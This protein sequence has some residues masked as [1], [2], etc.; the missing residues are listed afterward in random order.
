[1]DSVKWAKFKGI[2]ALTCNAGRLL[3]VKRYRGLSSH[4]CTHKI[5]LSEKWP[6]KYTATTTTQVF[7]ETVPIFTQRA[8]ADVEDKI[9]HFFQLERLFALEDI[10]FVF[11][12]G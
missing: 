6:L 4:T 1:M 2:I 9:D 10:H 12:Y 3:R 8:E 5:S 7:P 11:L